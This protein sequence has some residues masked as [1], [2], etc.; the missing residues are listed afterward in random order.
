MKTL[1]ISSLFI[2]L[3]GCSAIPSFWDDNESMLA[4]EVRYAVDKLECDKNQE[5]QV[6]LINSRL[7][8]FEL[9]SESRGSDDIREMQA[10]MRQ[11]VDGLVKDKSNNE[12]FCK[13]KKRILVKQSADIADAVM[14]RY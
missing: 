6:L 11:T 2:L 9:Y 12:I 8:R 3:S 10:L 5:P 14:G 4:V 13:M 1:L 7:R